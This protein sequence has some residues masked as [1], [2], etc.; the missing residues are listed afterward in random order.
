MSG[1]SVLTND[2]V[3]A[4]RETIRQLSDEN[5]RLR[6]K[7]CWAAESEWRERLQ[8]AEK[9]LLWASNRA[10]ALDGIDYTEGRPNWHD[11]YRMARKLAR[12]VKTLEG[13]SR[14]SREAYWSAKGSVCGDSPPSADETSSSET[15][16]VRREA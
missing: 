4:M 10:A 5:E 15:K 3:A 16:P 9:N 6:D 1:K 11:L 8:T 13:E 2:I 7:R 14:R 12:S